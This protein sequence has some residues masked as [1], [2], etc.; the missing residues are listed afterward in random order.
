M[1]ICIHNILGQ[2]PETTANADRILS[3]FPYIIL[4]FSFSFQ[5][6]SKKTERE[7]IAKSRGTAKIAAI[8]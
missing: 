1:M 8:R 3:L 5:G 6:R 7:R 2:N 4:S